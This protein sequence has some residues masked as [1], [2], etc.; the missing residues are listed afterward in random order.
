V[1]R[2]AIIVFIAAAGLS[3]MAV[4]TENTARRKRL[5]V[6]AAVCWAIVVIGFLV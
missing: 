1:K 6:A 2:L 3:W 4:K 5:A